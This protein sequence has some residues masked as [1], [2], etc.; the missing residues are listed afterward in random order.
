MKEETIIRLLLIS[1]ALAGCRQDNKNDEI[2]LAP[3]Q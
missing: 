1:L 2:P 3:D